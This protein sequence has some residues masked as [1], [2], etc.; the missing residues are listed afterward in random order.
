MSA[1]SIALL[2]LTI[3][4]AT[5]GVPLAAV[6]TDRSAGRESMV[7]TALEKDGS[8]L[9]TP[10]SFTRVGQPVGGDSGG[11]PEQVRIFR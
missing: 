8:Q 3:A 7:P 1:P 2:G 11:K 5:V 9:S 4:I 6:L 10:I